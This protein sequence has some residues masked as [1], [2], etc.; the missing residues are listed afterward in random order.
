MSVITYIKKKYDFKLIKGEI[1]S[2]TTP[3]V[4]KDNQLLLTVFIM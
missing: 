2:I 3:P 4:K 1:P